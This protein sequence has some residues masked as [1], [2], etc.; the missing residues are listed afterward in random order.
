MPG[1]NSQLQNAPDP[2]ILEH[3]VKY[4]ET[5]QQHKGSFSKDSKNRKEKLKHLT[6][7]VEGATSCQPVATIQRTTHLTVSALAWKVLH[8][9]LRKWTFLSPWSPMAAVGL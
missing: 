8:E 1:Q 3:D 9:W 2:Q 5:R 7:F 6:G 4:V